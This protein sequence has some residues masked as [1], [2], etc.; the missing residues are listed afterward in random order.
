MVHLLATVSDAVV[1]LITVVVNGMSREVSPGM[2][3]L[4]LAQLLNLVPDAVICEYNGRLCRFDDFS[5][6]TV[7]AGDVIEWM[8][9]M[10]GGDLS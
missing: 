8:H 6:I 4:G 2:T 5:Q 1:T 7:Q 3:L 10:G 9:F